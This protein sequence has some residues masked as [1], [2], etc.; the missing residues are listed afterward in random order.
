M[1]QWR[2]AFL[3]KVATTNGSLP[4]ILTLLEEVGSRV[5]RRECRVPLPLP[6]TLRPHRDYHVPS[7][8]CVPG[9]QHTDPRRHRRRERDREMSEAQEELSVDTRRREEARVARIAAGMS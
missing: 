5:M 1:S 7:N 4:V 2:R 6:G 8:C 9:L 3:W